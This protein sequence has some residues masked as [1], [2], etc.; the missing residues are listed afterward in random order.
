MNRTVAHL[1]RQAGHLRFDDLKS[2]FFGTR[3]ERGHP[4]AANILGSKRLIFHYVIYGKNLSQKFDDTAQRCKPSGAGVAEIHGNDMIV[5]VQGFLDRV[6]AWILKKQTQ[7]RVFTHELGHNLGLHHGGP[8]KQDPTY[9]E[10]GKYQDVHRNCKPHYFSLMN[11]SYNY[12]NVDLANP[13]D[14]SR[15]IVGPLNESSLIEVDGLRGWPNRTVVYGLNG[16]AK[17]AQPG[18][19]I[20]WNGVNGF[21]SQTVQADVNRIEDKRCGDDDGNGS[22]DLLTELGGYS[23]WDNLLFKFRDSGEFADAAHMTNGQIEELT[24]EE[25]MAAADS[26]DFDGD[27]FSNLVDNCPDVANPGQEDT[28]GD[29][30]GDACSAAGL[31]LSDWSL[32]F[33]KQRVGTTSTV[34]DV[35]LMNDGTAILNISISH[36]GDFGHTTTCEPSLAVDANCSIRVTFTPVVM[37]ERNGT[38]SIFSNAPGSPHIVPLTGTGIA[39]VLDISPSVVSHKYVE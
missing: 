20:D 4:N 16:V 10:N 23:D 32:T 31:A 9:L 2:I 25:V 8:I 14:Y 22:Q 15:T 19:S 33:D 36:T 6:K 11:Y 21:E 1:Q 38:L 5:T 39:P 13:L 28:D 24:A 29:G 26:V 18:G 34:Q 27:G 12:R 35:G 37:G 7:E 3:D 17:F 30:I